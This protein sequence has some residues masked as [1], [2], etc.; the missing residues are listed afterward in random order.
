[1]ALE[2]Q[3]VL[4]K[5]EKAL[6]FYIYNEAVKSDGVCLL[7]PVDIFASLSLDLDFEQNELDS[8]LKALELDDYF[9]VTHSDKKGEFFYCINLHHK[10]LAFARVE[11]AFRS[12]LKLKILLALLTALITV[13]ATWGLRLIL[14]A[15]GVWK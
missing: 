7:R 1:M 9:D 11:R 14:N 3:N 4:T 13:T 2:K 10:G 15:M 6:M 5:K 8:T 12:N